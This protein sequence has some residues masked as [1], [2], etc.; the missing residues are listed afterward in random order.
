MIKISQ[1][2]KQHIQ[3]VV[4]T[5]FY[6]KIFFNLQIFILTKGVLKQQNYL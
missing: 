5:F 3:T 6:V 1:K 4:T 2:K